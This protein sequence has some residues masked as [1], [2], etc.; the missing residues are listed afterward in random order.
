M[1]LDA[2]ATVEV[3]DFPKVTRRGR[4]SPT[5]SSRR[6]DAA[7]A[8]DRRGIIFSPTTGGSVLGG[9][10]DPEAS[11]DRDQQ[12]STSSNRP[13]ATPTPD[14]SRNAEPTPWCCCASAPAAATL[15]DV[16]TDRRRRASS[17]SDDL[18]A[19]RALAKLDG[20]QCEIEGFGPIPRAT[21]ERLL[22]DCAVGRV[23]MKGRSQILDLGRRTRTVPDRLRRAIVL[24]DEHCQFPGCRAPA[25]WC[26]AHHLVLVDTRRRDQPRQLLTAV[27]APPRGRPRRRLEA[28]TRTQRPY[29]G[30]R[31]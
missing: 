28:R 23:V 11:A 9:F 2:A 10:L 20:L 31:A 16:A 26:D 19:G 7:F 13:K 12:T 8:F 6:R 21:A 30:G 27:P 25:S 24:R 29:A 3:Q 17:V 1:L 18:L 4:R 15:P 5:T 14:P 22:C